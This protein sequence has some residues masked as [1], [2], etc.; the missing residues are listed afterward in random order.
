[1]APAFPINSSQLINAI[2]IRVSTTAGAGGIV[3]NM[4]FV[5]NDVSQFAA[6]AV[7]CTL[8]LA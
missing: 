8:V 1:M 2:M 3:G 4:L 6:I 7:V 5:R